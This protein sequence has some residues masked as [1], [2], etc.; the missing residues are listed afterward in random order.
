[1]L[2]VHRRHVVEPIEVADRLQIGLVLDQ[3]LGAAVQEADV[4]VDAFHDLAVQL[5]HE[6]QHA[7]GRGVLGAEVDV[8]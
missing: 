7:V 1:M 3:L 6:A 8:E 2:L 5:Q 4:G